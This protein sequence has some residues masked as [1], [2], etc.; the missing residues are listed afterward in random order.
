MKPTTFLFS[1]L[2]V[3]LQFNAAAQSSI[4]SKPN[5]IFILAD[6]LGYADLSFTGGKDVKPLI[7]M[8]LQQRGFF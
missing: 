6:D 3:F 4:A 5:I 7:S 1:L 2:M 8:L